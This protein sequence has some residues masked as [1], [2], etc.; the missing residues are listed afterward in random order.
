MASFEVHARSP[1]VLKKLDSIKDHYL[2]VL[3]ELRNANPPLPDVFAGFHIWKVDTR[4]AP[5]RM[6]VHWGGGSLCQNMATEPKGDMVW[7]S[8]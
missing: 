8:R 4:L 2:T 6:Y 3:I 5:C 7:I 1:I